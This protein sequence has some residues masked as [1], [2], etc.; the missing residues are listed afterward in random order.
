MLEDNVGKGGN[1]SSVLLVC[2]NG[3]NNIITV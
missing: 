3:N 1:G 2:F